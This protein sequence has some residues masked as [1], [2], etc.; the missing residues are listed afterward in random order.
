MEE[1]EPKK[2]VNANIEITI[3]PRNDDSELADS[4]A[5]EIVSDIE[6]FVDEHLK[7]YEKYTLNA[8][9]SDQ[10]STA[11]FFNLISSLKD[12]SILGRKLLEAAPKFDSII[13]TSNSATPSGTNSPSLADTKS[14]FGRSIQVRSLRGDRNTEDTNSE[15]LLSAL[16]ESTSSD[17]FLV[18]YSSLDSITIRDMTIAALIY[19]KCHE[20]FTLA[21]DVQGVVMVL[22]KTKFLI[23]NILAPKNQMELITK[24]L[25]SI[26]RYSEM[27]YVFDLFRDKSQFEVLLSKGVEKT[28]ELRIALF[29]YVKRNPE[30][31]ALVTLNF[32]MFREIA[33]SLEASATNRLDKIVSK[34]K[35]NV[36]RKRSSIVDFATASISTS[37]PLT[38]SMALTTA[39]STNAQ[40]QQMSAQQQ[41]R[42]HQQLKGSS[43]ETLIASSQQHAAQVA[44]QSAHASSMATGGGISQKLSSLTIGTGIIGGS[45]ANIMTQQQQVTPD[46]RACEVVKFYSRDILNYCLVELVDASDC[47]SK[48]G[49]YK[50]S[51]Q[52]A[53]RAKLVALQIALLPI[54][55]KVLDL[56]QTELN[57]LIV[58]FESFTEAHIVAEAYDY[59]LAWRQALF[60][61]VVLQGN[62]NYLEQFCHQCH[63][64]SALVM[65]LVVLYKQYLNNNSKQ[66]SHETQLNLARSMRILLAKLN[67]V[68]LRCKL[69]TQLSFDDSKEELMR[70]PA[71]GA[72]LRDLR[73]A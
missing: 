48:A 29:N 61:N 18:L 51:N 5:K 35:S 45:S 15:D 73:L 58:S 21:H 39:P 31:Y 63:L 56:Q 6:T 22:R 69:Y 62:S 16:V 72:H 34:S 10:D 55:V 24:L 68:E 47:F 27:N 64:S 28:P 41:Q 17:D 33:E 54:S 36:I 9:N 4:I 3:P 38:A 46:S 42:Q 12:V 66:L 52:C 25:T 14:V 50:R 71:I 53:N 19:I 23:L 44:Q 32:S 67:D 8:P 26:G 13:R 2:R 7:K 49:C 11:Q 40:H 30:F 59:H 1:Q 57:D 70:D 37:S 65:E 43:G 60:N 20:C